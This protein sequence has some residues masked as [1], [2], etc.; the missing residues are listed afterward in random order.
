M[1]FFRYASIIAPT[2]V[3]RSGKRISTA[4][5]EEEGEGGAA[6]SLLL[7]RGTVGVEVLGE[8]LALS[9]LSA[10]VESFEEDE[11]APERRRGGV[12]HGGGGAMRGQSGGG[13]GGKGRERDA[14]CPNAGVGEG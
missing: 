13:S 6:S 9:G 3:V 10:A 1:A 2:A 11:G 8:Q 7:V 12:T 4:E 5:E 14:T